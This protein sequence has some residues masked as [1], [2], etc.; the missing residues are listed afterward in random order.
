[1][2]RSVGSIL[3]GIASD[4]YGRRWPFIINNLLFV[5]LELVSTRM[6]ELFEYC[7]QLVGNQNTWD[8]CQCNATWNRTVYCLVA[9]QCNDILERRAV[10]RLEYASAASEPPDL[11][12]LGTNHD[13]RASAGFNYH[14]CQGLDF[15]LILLLDR[16]R[17]RRMANAD[18]LGYR[19]LPKLLPIP[20]L[21]CAVRNCHGW[22]VRQCSS[23]STGRSTRGSTRTHE[24][25][26]AAGGECSAVTHQ[27]IPC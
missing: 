13:C 25:A 26:P 6:Q 19:F 21:P 9:D 11:A 12:M 17:L 10:P 24:W 7:C 14:E 2:F 18:T 16:E 5:V 15:C 3:F 8:P 22:S 23:D 1:M 4:R 20:R 27:H